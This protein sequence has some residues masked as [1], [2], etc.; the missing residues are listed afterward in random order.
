[1]VTFHRR[2]QWRENRGFQSVILPFLRGVLLCTI[3]LAIYGVF[4]HRADAAA[5]AADNKAATA[6][7]KQAAY[8][9]ALETTLSKCL[10]RGD[11]AVVI[12]DEVW[13]CGATNSGIK[14]K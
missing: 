6:L 9:K 5:A 12:G 8:I 13:F 14:A 7:A 3:A 10:S 2:R 1:M 4:S 11:N